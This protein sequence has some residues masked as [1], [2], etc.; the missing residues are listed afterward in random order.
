MPAARPSTSASS[1]DEVALRRRCARLRPHDA[2]TSGASAWGVR[3]GAAVLSRPPICVGCR[4]RQTGEAFAFG[5]LAGDRRTPIFGLP[6]TRSA[7]GQLRNCLYAGASQDDGTWR[8]IAPLFLQATRLPRR[9]DGKSTTY[10]FGSSATTVGTTSPRSEPRAA[11][12]WQR[13]RWRTQSPSFPMV[14]ASRPAAPSRR[15][16]CR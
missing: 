1:D 2:V 5:P 3:R 7:D 12:N 11:T 10:G 6:A 9:V 16:F 13:L 4:S 14:M 8:T 15:S